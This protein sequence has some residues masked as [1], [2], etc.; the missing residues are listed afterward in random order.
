MR[1]G[2]VVRI[3]VG[4]AL[5]VNFADARD[6][7]KALVFRD[8]DGAG[9]TFSFRLPDSFVGFPWRRGRIGAGWVAPPLPPAS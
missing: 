2:L 9:M 7:D 8:L 3:A 1:A 5:D 4:A 6:A